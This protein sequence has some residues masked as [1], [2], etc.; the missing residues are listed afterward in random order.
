MKKITKVRIG[1]DIRLSVDLRQY[2]A[3]HKLLERKV[4]N[5]RARDYELIDGDPHVNKWYEVYSPDFH[6]DHD[7]DNVYFK[8]LGTPISI[9]SVKAVLINTTREREYAEHLR[10]KSRFISRFPIEPGIEAFHSTPH[11]V[12]GSGYPTWRAY[13]T[14]HGFLPYRGF[15]VRP[16]WNGIYKPLPV[17][18]DIEYRAGV[19]ATDHQN[20][21]EVSFPAEHQLHV[22]KYKLVVVAKIFAPGYNNQN[23]KTITVDIPDVFELVKTSEEGYNSDITVKVMNLRDILPDG[24]VYDASPKDVYV[25]EGDVDSDMNRIRL[26]RTDMESVDIDM[27]SLTGWM[28]ADA[29]R[30]IDEPEEGLY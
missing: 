20:V 30:V 5:P 21:V 27:S 1:N 24:D 7:G 25:D 6:A 4:Y 2:L 3:D 9:R 8:P 23:L 15:G 16:G 17:I 14:R 26:G 18:N 12:C 11:D 10:K 29:D 22:G 13:P 28:E 19:Y